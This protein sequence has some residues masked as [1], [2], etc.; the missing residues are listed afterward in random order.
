[1]PFIL[2]ACIAI[3][4]HCVSFF[5]VCC[6]GHQWKQGQWTKQEVDTLRQN[7]AQYCEVSLWSYVLSILSR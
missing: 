1:M 6:V 5:C 3:R 2:V 4:L 7:I